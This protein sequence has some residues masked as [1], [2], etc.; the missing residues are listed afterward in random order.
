M[1]EA[2]I[3]TF[4]C[5]SMLKK[6]KDSLLYIVGHQDTIK[7][8]QTRVADH[9]N[10]SNLASAA[11]A[12]IQKKN[13]DALQ[14]QVNALQTAA[15]ADANAVAAVTATDGSRIDMDTMKASISNM[16]TGLKVDVASLKAELLAMMKKIEQLGREPKAG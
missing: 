14:T 13:Y 1:M 12:A 3:E 7:E 16:E 6:F 8:N 4:N 10:K 11:N 15:T 2:S 9:M 5:E